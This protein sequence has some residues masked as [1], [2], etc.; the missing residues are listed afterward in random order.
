MITRQKVVGILAANALIISIVL[1]ARKR[2]RSLFV[3]R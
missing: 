1:A 3:R 2:P